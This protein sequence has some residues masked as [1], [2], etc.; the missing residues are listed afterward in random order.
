MRPKSVTEKEPPTEVVTTSRRGTRRH[1]SA[2][3]KS[4]IVLEGLYVLNDN[5]LPERPP[6]VFDQEA[7]ERV[8]RPACRVRHDQCDRAR[9]VPLG[10]CRVQSGSAA[11][12]G[13]QRN[14]MIRLTIM[15]RPHEPTDWWPVRLNHNGR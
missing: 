12:S 2:E 4:R 9:R 5:G 11:R 6:H 15:V 10:E 14:R 1:F 8:C 7:C 13:S 3:D